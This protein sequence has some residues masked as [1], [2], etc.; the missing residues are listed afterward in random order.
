MYMRLQMINL[1]EDT[2]KMTCQ[3]VIYFGHEGRNKKVATERR[4]GRPRSKKTASFTAFPDTSPN[5]SIRTRLVVSHENSDCEAEAEAPVLANPSLSSTSMNYHHFI[6]LSH[7]DSESEAEIV[8]P[9]PPNPYS[10]RLRRSTIHTMSIPPGGVQTVHIPG[11]DTSDS[12]ESV[13]DTDYPSRHHSELITGNGTPI[14][15]SEPI[16]SPILSQIKK[17]VQKAIWENKYIDIA[18]LL[19]AS[20]NQ[21]QSPTFSLHVDNQSSISISPSHEAKKIATIESWTSAFIR[22]IAVY[23]HRYPLETSQLMKY[24]EI[25]RDIAS[26][27]PGLPFAF[28]DTRFRMA[29]SSAP[30]QWDRLHTEIWLMA[31]TFFNT[32]SAQT[33]PFL[34]QFLENTCWNHNNGTGC[35]NPKCSQ[36]HVCGFCRGQHTAFHCT[37]SNK[38]F[39]SQ[40]AQNSSTPN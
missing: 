21:H 37:Y 39:T 38:Q 11:S 22:F 12:D 5:V 18:S 1:D 20:T 9:A 3:G 32:V 40:A 29:R 13:E 34:R 31:C 19:P 8:I 15:Y 23:S 17:S 2:P 24:M 35:H 4:T 36:P 10:S 33:Q 6:S 30:L 28:Y 27:R 25:V 7:E 26:R 16:S 14:Q